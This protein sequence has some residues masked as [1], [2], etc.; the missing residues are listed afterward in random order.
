METSCHIDLYVTRVVIAIIVSNYT[1]VSSLQEFKKVSS[2]MD[3]DIGIK[4]L[5]KCTNTGYTL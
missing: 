1:Y 4:L 2:Y 3:M 5:S